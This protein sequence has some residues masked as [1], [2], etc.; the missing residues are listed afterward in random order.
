MKQTL[1]ISFIMSV[2]HILASDLWLMAANSENFSW[3]KNIILLIYLLVFLALLSRLKP[4]KEI[5]ICGCIVGFIGGYVGTILA[6]KHFP[7]LFHELDFPLWQ[8]QLRFAFAC[9]G[10]YCLLGSAVYL[11][12]K[13]MLNKPGN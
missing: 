13:Y 9:L 5:L 7:G 12:R 8:A 1:A 11:C 3:L 6:S 2:A 10:I 4:L